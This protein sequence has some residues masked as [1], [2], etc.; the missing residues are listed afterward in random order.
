MVSLGLVVV[1]HCRTLLQVNAL[2]NLGTLLFAGVGGAVT[3]S[4]LLPGWVRAVAPATPAYWAMQGF[5]TVIVDG[6]GWTAAVV[7]TGVLLAFSAVLGAVAAG[8]FRADAAK[9]AWA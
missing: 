9:V 7:P 3:P 6:G 8:R 5:R 2:S 1:A 4:F